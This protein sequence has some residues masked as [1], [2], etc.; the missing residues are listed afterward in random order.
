MK[1]LSKLFILL[2]SLAV[3]VVTLAIV[4][5]ADSGNVAK[6]DG[7]EYGTLY[8]ALKAAD[9]NGKE[10]ILIG[11]AEIDAT[12][13]VENS[14]AIDL[15]GHTLT[16][17]G[18][19]FILS[20]PVSLTV[21]GEGTIDVTDPIFINASAN[22]DGA[23]TVNVTGN[24]TG[25]K[26]FSYGKLV[27]IKSG[28]AN[29]KNLSVV[30]SAVPTNQGVFHT[31][32]ESDAKLDFLA[33]EV[34]MEDGAT[35]NSSI[36]RLSGTSSVKLNY[37]SFV[38]N[39]VVFGVND[40]KSTDLA[41]EA[42][43]SYL[44]A[45]VKAS[46]SNNKNHE[47]GVIGTYAAISCKMVFNNTV[48]EGSFRPI[49]VNATSDA[50]IT[51]NNSA[52]KNNGMQ[53]GQIARTCSIIVNAGSMLT[54]VNVPESL[55]HAE[56]ESTGTLIVLKAGARMNY[57]IYNTLYINN[58]E[59]STAGVRYGKEVAN[60]DST[61]LVLEKII[62]SENFTVIYD[63]IGNTEAPFVVVE[64]TYET[65]GDGE[66]VET[67]PT[68]IDFSAVKYTS[69]AAG[70]PKGIIWDNG[71]NGAFHASGDAVPLADF[72]KWNP[73]G[74][75]SGVSFGGN[76]AIRLERDE[77]NEKSNNT[78]MVFGVKN[79]IAHENHQVFV[80]EA[81]F[82]FDS[83]IGFLGGDLAMC[84]RG[85]NNGG[86]YGNGGIKLSSDGKATFGTNG[87]VSV[88]LELGEWNHATIVIYS[89]KGQTG[90]SCK[91]KA[92]F[93]VNGVLLGSGNGYKISGSN[94]NS[95]FIWGLRYDAYMP[96][97]ELGSSIVFDNCSFM[98]YDDYKV[99]SSDDPLLYSL[100]DAMPMNSGKV[101]NG[102]TVGGVEFGS[103]N[104]ALVVGNELGVYPTLKKDV[105]NQFVTEDGT[106]IANGHTIGFAEGSASA[107][108]NF[109]EN[110]E[111]YSY[112]F[113]NAF[114]ELSVTYQWF[115]GNIN[116]PS[117][118]YDNSKYY[119]TEVKLGG[120]PEYT[121]ADLPSA[122]SHIGQ[123]ILVSQHI[124]WTVNYGSDIPTEF[125]PVSI[126]DAINMADTP[127]KVFPVFSEMTAVT[128]Y[129]FVILDE[130][131]NFDRGVNSNNDIYGSDWTNRAGKDIKLEYGET[132]V[133][134]TSQKTFIGNFNSLRTA[135]GVDKVFSFD[136]NGY[137][138]NIRAEKNS[139][140]KNPSYFQVKTG[141]TFNLYSSVPGAKVS[142][143][144]MTS[145]SATKITGGNLFSLRAS[146]SSVIADNVRDD[147]NHNSHINIGTVT[148]FGNT[149]AGS[150]IAFNVD[151]LVDLQN[152]DKTCTVNVDGV[153]I[154]RTITEKSALF[155][156]Y[157][158][159]A[160]L[161]VTNC[162]IFLPNGG[163]VINGNKS[164]LSDYNGNG[165]V[166]QNDARDG[167]AD[168]AVG[169]RA[170][171]TFI[172]DRCY[173]F[174]NLNSV[175]NN[176]NIV[177]NDYTLKSAVFTNCVTN[178]RINPSN[179][180]L[181]VQIGDGCLVYNPSANKAE[182]VAAYK[183]NRN[184]TF[185]SYTDADF[186][187]VSYVKDFTKVSN[188]N[189]TYNYATFT[190]ALPSSDVSADLV[191]PYFDYKYV[192]ADH[193]YNV[194]I[195][196]SEGNEFSNEQYA[197]GAAPETPELSDI[198]SG[199]SLSYVFD[200]TFSPEL[201]D[202]VV[203]DVTLVPN[204]STVSN[205]AGLEANVSLGSDFV[206]NLMIPVAYKN[207][208]TSVSVGDAALTLSE[209]GD[210][211][212]AS[213]PVSAKCVTDMIAFNI[214]STESSYEATKSV[215]FSVADYAEL[216]LKNESGTYT[217]ADR[218]MVWYA[219]NY[220]ANASVYF[221]G[222]EDAALAALLET[223]IDA[224]GT[225]EAREYADVLESTGL[226]SVIS[227][228]TLKLDEVPAYS[229][230]VKAGFA[231]TV[232]VET[233]KGTYTFN[234]AASDK[235]SKLVITGMK[236]Y[237]LSETAVITV[238]G[239]IGNDAVEITDGKFNLAT[240][241]NYHS[242]NVANGNAS[243]EAI[244]LI[245]ALYD[246]VSAAQKYMNGTLGEIVTPEEEPEAPAAA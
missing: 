20:G 199:T 154:V 144:G 203:A 215:S 6:V 53:G 232:S 50:L 68:G 18:S 104:E 32:A 8:E 206:L 124:G 130:N 75:I 94:G 143:H 242:Q 31:D 237:E 122:T 140:G 235:D 208:I 120:I 98:A 223:Y 211:L 136:L 57:S 96:D 180:G 73:N 158:S 148:R 72:L 89:D 118:L 2:L 139:T 95:A 62:G 81:D 116:N 44:S 153:N 219:V 230:V 152:G 213:I 164:G 114:N 91:G 34:L 126:S 146:G 90:T 174:F 119:T 218:M 85:A 166:D 241:A 182:G 69:S 63:P 150:N 117:D 221:E 128:G 141:E 171:A 38:S 9:E 207:Y 7:K 236:A 1:K 59:I 138:M 51:L 39:R 227:Y 24:E 108:I 42:D 132:L 133:F 209:S 48:I 127:V 82:A 88:D 14:V 204:Y 246:Y 165:T 21:K 176:G 175:T 23:P 109:D 240:F 27:N 161:T 26:V 231:G 129:D 58:S 64:R 155:N 202:G 145:D 137:E 15:N 100:S 226:S 186:V 105:I 149:Y 194:I 35:S 40:L 147:T 33:V 151:C 214:V 49:C 55:N 36:V 43:N 172:F 28:V 46:G 184:M 181:A 61:E 197:I 198:Y 157:Y 93:Y 170:A 87:S 178:G 162:N 110:N 196:D 191:L 135:T 25:I 189:I 188:S 52:I 102:V 37:C 239:T 5:S 210:Y 99:S 106:V 195:T 121:G 167:E 134:M 45:R 54:A 65:N 74:I 101:S 234:V 41:I 71:V 17:C 163:A 217:V 220:A 77:L 201:P 78:T 131:G 111:I 115:V 86:N 200:G 228:A 30:A 205:V 216:I 112:V 29:F 3:I 92:Y 12:Y 229:F 233:S 183:Y 243:E 244:D 123:D 179:V 60:G 113:N 169:Y 67:T 190:Y 173:M 193:V 192:T 83:A 66:T 103:V 168:G 222:A 16:A 142:I 10:L 238:V 70:A 224:K 125:A 177:G 47:I 185:G 159:C 22:A 11:D 225:D 80:A 4:V 79:G 19:A 156:N 245:N 107:L 56:A 84:I 212:V 13:K 160:T 187:T 76:D 97:A